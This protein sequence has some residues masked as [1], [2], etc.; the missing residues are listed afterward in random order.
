M[1][2]FTARRPESAAADSSGIPTPNISDVRLGS[3][4]VSEV[5]VVSVPNRWE[6]VR[7]TVAGR[8]DGRHGLLPDPEGGH[9]Q[10]TA[11]V[12]DE[13]GSIIDSEQLMLTRA[14]S[15]IDELTERLTTEL[16][17][18]RSDVEELSGRTVETPELDTR[19]API[20]AERRRERET[21]SR[22][23]AHRSRLDKIGARIQEIERELAGLVML[24]SYQIVATGQRIDRARVTRQQIVDVYWRWFVRTHPEESAVRAGYPIPAVDRPPVTPALVPPRH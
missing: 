15:R 20:L 19:V 9:T 18:C 5:G 21:A 4:L 12:A 23:G 16:T 8:R 11:R 10:Y 6:R 7:A 24:R 17:Q 22:Q 14:L 1:F 13:Y 2:P 3:S